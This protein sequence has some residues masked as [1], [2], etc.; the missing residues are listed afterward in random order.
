MSLPKMWISQA[1]KLRTLTYERELDELCSIIIHDYKLLK[2]GMKITQC[3]LRHYI[4][5]KVIKH[6]KLSTECKV[7]KKKNKKNISTLNYT[8]K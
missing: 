8:H 6:F 5:N 7:Q 2:Y 1:Q 3:G 4:S